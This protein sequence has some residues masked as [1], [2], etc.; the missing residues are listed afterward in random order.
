MPSLLL[1]LFPVLVGIALLHSAVRVLLSPS[2][3]V[4]GP[5]LARFTRLWYLREIHRGKF[6]ETNIELHKK[7][8]WLR[9]Y[10]IQTCSVHMMLN[11]S[12]VT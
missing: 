3:D 10:L 6:H 5:F 8:G 9:P 12:T 11:D 7:H 1:V 2:R 4:P